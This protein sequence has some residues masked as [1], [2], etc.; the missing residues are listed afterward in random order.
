MTLVLRT[1]RPTLPTHPARPWR[2]PPSPACAAVLCRDRIDGDVV[3]EET[4][5][6]RRVHGVRGARFCPEQIRAFVLG[7]AFLPDRGDAIDI[8]A[9]AGPRLEAGEMRLQIHRQCR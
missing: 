8:G 1:R 9:R 4:R 5:A 3:S 7:D 6:D 2:R